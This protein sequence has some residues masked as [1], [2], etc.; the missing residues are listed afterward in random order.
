MR[1]VE[2]DGDPAA[3]SLRDLWMAVRIE[4]GVSVRYEG[5]SFIAASCAG[6]ECNLRANWGNGGMQSF[7]ALVQRRP[8]KADSVD[9]L[10]MFDL[11]GRAAL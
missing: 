2:V 3:M 5:L 4:C 10:E 9:T 6:G 7:T 11:D 1:V 8:R